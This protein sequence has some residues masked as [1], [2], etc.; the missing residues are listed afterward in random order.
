MPNGTRGQTGEAGWQIPAPLGRL[1]DRSVLLDRLDGLLQRPLTVVT[2][3][4]GS[5][6]TTLV[7]QWC[8]QRS[9]HPVAWVRVH[10]GD[11]D[12]AR[13]IARVAT[14]IVALAGALQCTG[15]DLLGDGQVR[16]DQAAIDR[17]AT[18]LAGAHDSVLV[19]DG[20]NAPG[21]VGLYADLAAALDRATDCG[22]RLVVVGRYL[23]P[24]EIVPLQLRGAAM[25]IDAEALEL[26]AGE[27]AAVIE[28]RSGWSISASTAEQLAPRLEGWM[29]AAVIVGMTHPG[30]DD[31]SGDELFDTA[32]DDIESYV[33][34]E[35]LNPMPDAVRTF[36]M[37][38]SC[39][40][41]MDAALCDA[42]TG[43]RD[44]EKQLN[45]MRFVGVPIKRRASRGG[46][47]RY[48]RPLREVLEIQVLR[49][50]PAERHA[51]LQV[52]AE[53]YSRHVRPFD[54][55]ECWVRLGQWDR[56]IDVIMLHLQ[57]IVVTDEVSRLADL[58][59]R[60]P[61]ALLRDH[62]ELALQGAWVLRMDGRIGAAY[63]LLA[64]Y[65]PYMTVVG[66]MFADLGRS[67]VA[68]WAEDVEGTLSFA[69]AAITRCNDAGDDAFPATSLP[70]PL[71]SRAT[72]DTFRTLAHGNALLASAYGGMW[73]RG[74]PHLV[75]V[76]AESAAILPQ[77]QIVQL[78]GNR[79]TFL[80]LAGRAA[81]ATVEV[82]HALAVAADTGLLCHRASA[83]AHYAMG[84]VHRLTLRHHEATAMFERSAQLAETNGRRN[85]ITAIV[86]SQAH[87]L[88]DAGKPQEAI[89]L[90][91]RHQASNH[92]RPPRTLAGRL[93]AAEA[94]A[95]ASS[96]AH[97]RGLRAL[98]LVAPTPT[99]ATVRIAISLA[100]NDLARA[101]DTVERWP[102]EPTADS[103][104]R[105]ALA[106]AVI[107]ETAGDRPKAS[108]SF[109]GALS[110][111]A[112]HQ[113]LQPFVEF[114]P[115]ITRL[116][117]RA[118]ST[119][120]ETRAVDLARHVHALLAGGKVASVA[121][122]LTDRE[123]LV[124]SYLSQGVSLGE[125]ASRIHLSVNTVK[126]HV[127]TIY[128]KLGV[129]TRMEAIR[130][131]N[132]LSGSRSED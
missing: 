13:L 88:V 8:R 5:G 6:K 132:S 44:S 98:D 95:L 82:R 99:T 111:A 80:V 73:T 33:R 42:V 1:V 75:D 116:L 121:P 25:H 76:S 106:G 56:A 118:D 81:E 131:W 124:L 28:S 97:R 105:R 32:F 96:G 90:I 58:I 86:A 41:D 51:A 110:V 59:V 64:V 15:D 122:R 83:D 53:W 74:E 108:A 54:A 14:A 89:G 109:H 62:V 27:V 77:M 85:L 29:A 115:L 47:F 103:A 93:A 52:A 46:S 9:P 102:V 34:F 31:R 17:L 120:T 61:P 60:A 38:T 119:H 63:E 100:V 2:G 35:I 11:D 125:V 49:E 69:E 128:R 57:Q 104:V 30:G 71:Y 18:A 26:D 4:A 19:I 24:P 65:E 48:L 91:E 113:L 129:G 127:K 10:R 126:S 22:I 70:L 7:A 21:P 67:S 92:H 123:T 40:D 114:G 36:L 16:L 84:E 50:S 87:L 107:Y 12:A 20:V 117:Q 68:S 3:P 66:R 101:R 55:A 39:V 130:V 94:R 79:A 23:P 72:A 37:L 43:R 112:D 45:D 78:Y